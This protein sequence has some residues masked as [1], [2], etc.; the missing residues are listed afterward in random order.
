MK[1]TAVIFSVFFSVSMMSQ[2]LNANAGLAYYNYRPNTPYEVQT[3]QFHYTYTDNYGTK[4]L[5]TDITNAN[6]MITG[7]FYQQDETEPSF[8]T[9]VGFEYGDRGNIFPRNLSAWIGEKTLAVG[10]LL[11]VE[12]MRTAEVV[13]VDYIPYAG[14]Y[15]DKEKRNTV[16]YIGHGTEVFGSAFAKVIRHELVTAGITYLYDDENYNADISGADIIFGDV[17]EDESVDIR[18]VILLNRAIFGKAELNNYA[19]LASDFN[20]DGMPDAEDSLILMKY[21]VGLITTFD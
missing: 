3:E 4:I 13:P 19:V 18:D 20:G 15:Y 11:Y 2:R 12:D 10:D 14:T 21:I 17:T 16:A 8:Y 7:V 1:K 6:W 5:E 9:A